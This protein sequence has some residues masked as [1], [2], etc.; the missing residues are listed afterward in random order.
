M[1]LARAEGGGRLGGDANHSQPVNLWY[2]TTEEVLGLLCHWST[3]THKE[4]TSEFPLN[5][6]RLL[7][8]MQ[9]VPVG[10][11]S[12]R[13]FQIKLDFGYL[14]KRADMITA[15]IHMLHN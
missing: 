11:C 15:G 6:K 8:K 14:T 9:L 12:L 3:G 4:T 7:F 5:Y 13:C 10:L 2:V 1:V